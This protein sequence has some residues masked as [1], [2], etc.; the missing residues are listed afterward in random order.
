MKSCTKQEMLR[1]IGEFSNML[2]GIGSNADRS[3]PCIFHNER[4][5]VRT[6]AHGDDYV[7]ARKRD[8]LGRSKEKSEEAHAIKTATLETPL[9]RSA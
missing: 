6:F 1:R 2:G 3:P 7:S 9:N 5:R 8:D 4:R